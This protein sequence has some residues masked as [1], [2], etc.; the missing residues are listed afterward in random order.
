MLRTRLTAILR[1]HRSAHPD[2]ALRV[3]VLVAAV[4][5]VLGG[6]FGDVRV[7]AVDRTALQRALKSTVLIWCRTTPA[8]STHGQRHD[9]GR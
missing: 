9:H 8:T 7:S 1:W 4:L 2:R 6:A 5:F 3:L